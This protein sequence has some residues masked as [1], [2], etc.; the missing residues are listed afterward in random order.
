MA[1]FRV[2]VENR[3]RK[4][5]DRIV[6][7]LEELE[8]GAKFRRTSWERPGGG[9]GEMSELRGELFEKGGC[10]FSAVHG[11]S[12]PAA[13]PGPAPAAHG[14]EVRPPSPEELAGNPFFATGVSLVMHPQNP[15]VPIAHMNVRYLEAAD[16]CWYGG[17]M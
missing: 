12:F 17:G 1:A 10:N 8:G 5:R 13:P 15:F 2:E 6:A 3:F 14:Q 7:R 4:L 9:G 11:P 16:V